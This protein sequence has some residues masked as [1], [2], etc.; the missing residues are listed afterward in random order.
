MA[1]A[2]AASAGMLPPLR[3]ELALYPGPRALDGSPTWTLHDPARNQFF[4]IGWPEFEMLSRWDAGDPLALLERLRAETTLDLEAEDVGDVA[5]FLAGHNLVR[6]ASAEST[7][8]LAAKA[9]RLRQHWAMW[10]L[11]NYLFLRIPLVRPDRWLDAA[12]PW[13]AWA[14][15]PAFGRSVFALGM[16]SLYLVARRWDEYLDTFTYLFSIEGAVYFALTLTLLKVV[17]ELGHAFTAKRYGCR[18]PSMG[19]AFLVLWPVLYTDV[20]ESWKLPSRR[21]RL[22]VGMA[23]MATE[24]VCAVFA[25]FAWSFLPDGPMRSAAFLVSTTTWVSTLLINLSPF[26]RFDGYFVFSDWLE[27]PNLHTRAFALARWWLRERLLALGD[28]PPEELPPGR[29]RFV[30]AFAFCT[31][32]YRV[33]LFLGIAA[34]V[35]HFTVKLLGIGLAAVEIG[36]FILRPIWGEAAMLW[37]LRGKFH[38][39]RRPLLSGAAVLL[40]LLALIVPW[41]SAVEAPA[42]FRSSR[43]D[44]VFAPAQGT[45]IGTLGV[46]NGDNVAKDAP[47]IELE[48]PDL[49]FKLAQ[50]RTDI[51]VL[52]WQ[53][54]TQGVA[55]DLLAHSRV[56]GHEYEAAYAQYRVFADE[57]QRLHVT[58]PIAGRVVDIADDLRPGMWIPPKAP[59]LSVVALGEP[60]I[61]AYVFEADLPRIAVGDRA[62]FYPD[63]GFLSA[64]EARVAAIDRANTRVLPENYLASRFGGGIPVREVREGEFVP[65]RAVYR[66]V[67][68]VEDGAQTPPRVVRGRV[69]IK[70]RGES[71]A[72]R[73]WRSVLS[74]LLRESGV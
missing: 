5:R 21:Q 28:P 53:L 34:L 48:S 17:H 16:L 11:K 14:F 60:E 8:S 69:V 27:M 70:G 10:L 52:E 25:T 67:L 23:G 59:L 31:W 73:A 71:L 2:A 39:G 57:A 38:R 30:I 33:S 56:A 51:A 18:V 41:R 43:I 44:R 26:M 20:T 24:L 12:Y 68:A 61:E 13:I 7:R 63:G 36:Y 1:V 42:L 22:A 49:A 35:Y 19:V 50:A 3:E 64:I 6:S 29:R 55:P 66:V 37:K 65:E 72:A 54:A 15:T 45:R 4:R 32:L 46:H 47:L 74:V 40:L 9:A 58:A 62:A